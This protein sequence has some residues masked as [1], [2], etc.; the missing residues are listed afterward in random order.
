MLS[1]FKKGE[2]RANGLWGGSILG[3]SIYTYT[4]VEK[5]ETYSLKEESLSPGMSPIR[6]PPFM[7][8]IRLK[9][10]WKQL[11]YRKKS[12]SL[13]IKQN[14][15]H[16]LMQARV[17]FPTCIP[18]HPSPH[19]LEKA[20]LHTLVLSW[21]SRGTC[22]RETSFLCYTL[23][24]SLLLFYLFCYKNLFEPNWRHTSGAKS[25]MFP[26]LLLF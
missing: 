9:P 25:Q 8:K 3:K 6:I 5:R 19:Q 7:P 22:V 26:S 11:T 15:F 21:F 18:F 24:P 16:D 14:A 2:G 10:C 1:F 4:E 20:D 12:K 23:T 17:P 13:C